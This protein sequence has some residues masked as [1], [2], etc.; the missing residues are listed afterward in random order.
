MTRIEKRLN[1]PTDQD[2]TPSRKPKRN[3]AE[4]EREANDLLRKNP[5][6]RLSSS[7][8]IHFPSSTSSRCKCGGIQ[9]A[10]FQ[11]QSCH[12]VERWNNYS[13]C[14]RTAC[15]RTAKRG[16]QSVASDGRQCHCLDGTCGW[17]DPSTIRIRPRCGIANFCP[18]GL[19]ANAPARSYSGKTSNSASS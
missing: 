1:R 17:G 16:P 8:P 11:I 10:R 19:I 4:T 3:E 15:F 6:S 18:S 2:S 12:R 9:L 7:Q 5:S 13:N 14:Q